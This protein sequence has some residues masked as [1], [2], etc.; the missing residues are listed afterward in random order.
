MIGVVVG[1]VLSQGRDFIKEARASSKKKRGARRLLAHHAMTL[2]DDSLDFLAK[3][4]NEVGAPEERIAAAFADV[5][6][7]EHVYRDQI[8]S[9]L[10]D[11]SDEL[12]VLFRDLDLASSGAAHSVSV[13]QRWS[14]TFFGARDVARSKIPTTLGEA[15]RQAGAEHLALFEV[16]RLTLC[17]LRDEATPLSARAAELCTVETPR[18]DLPAQQQLPPASDAP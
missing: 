4:I 8:A 6:S 18:L 5:T 12:I 9:R 15:L 10:D 14:S 16:A 1:F 11:L 13:L 17:R 7:S 3:R 2:A